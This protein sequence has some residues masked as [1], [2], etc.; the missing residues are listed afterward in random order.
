M[1]DQL[2]ALVA[3][4]ISDLM[5]NDD[6]FRAPVNIEEYDRLLDYLICFIRDECKENGND[7]IVALIQVIAANIKRDQITWACFYLGVLNKFRA[8][9]LNVWDQEAVDRLNAVEM[10]R[11][12]ALKDFLQTWGVKA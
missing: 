8:L 11:E 3:P 1:S 9:M 7:P 2:N 5:L 6:Q 4:D 12:E 10:R